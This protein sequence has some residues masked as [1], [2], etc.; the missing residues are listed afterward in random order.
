M[1]HDNE[2]VPWTER[3][4]TRAQ[5]CAVENISRDTLNKM[6]RQGFGPTWTV[7][8]GTTVERIT[9]AARAAWHARMDEWKAANAAPLAAA[10]RAQLETMAALG[11]LSIR[12]PR[13]PS[14]KARVR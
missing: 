3:N 9:P 7:F 10:R 12:S 5:L 14:R 13:H 11:Q 4:L 2:V 6:E 8:P 1:Y